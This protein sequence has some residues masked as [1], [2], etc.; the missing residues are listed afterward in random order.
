MM[1]A[2]LATLTL[3]TLI[4]D[5]DDMEMV[6]KGASATDAVEETESI[7]SETDVGRAV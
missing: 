7:D 2:V 6:A 4:L 1:D 3:E 5:I